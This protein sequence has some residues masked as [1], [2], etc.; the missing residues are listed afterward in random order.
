LGPALYTIPSDARVEARELRRCYSERLWLTRAELM[1]IAPDVCNQFREACGHDRVVQLDSLGAVREPLV[2]RWRLA[3]SFDAAFDALRPLAIGGDHEEVLDVENGPEGEPR[4]MITWYEP[5]SAE[6]SDPWREIG[7]LYV[8]D[9][10]LAAD[11][12]TSTLASRLIR[13]VTDRLGGAATLLEQ[14]SSAPVRLYTPE[15]SWTLA[16]QR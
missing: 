5:G 15:S 3:T 11:V 4:V 8:D 16:A 1:D 10:R 6:A 7:F 12:P 13:E 14:R 2:L 9:G